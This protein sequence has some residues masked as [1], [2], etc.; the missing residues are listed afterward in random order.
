MAYGNRLRFVLLTLTIMLACARVA[1]ACS[2][3]PD[4]TVLDAYD[5]ADVVIIA[6]AVAVEKASP[7][8]TAPPGQ[9][10]DGENYVDGVKSTTMRVERLYKG[11]LKIGDE[12][13]F[14]QGGGADCVWTFNEKSIGEEYL[15]YLKRF[16]ESAH[17]IAITCGRGGNLK[18]MGDDLLYLNKMEK[19]RGK[20]R[21]SGTLSFENQTDE[22]VAGRK[23]RIVGAGRTY[24][25]E[26]DEDGVYEVYD[27]PAGTYYIEPE[28]PRGWRVANFWLSYSPSF[29]GSEEV[30]SPKKIPITLK[31]KKHAGL[32]IRFE[33]DNAVRG[34]IYDPSGR[35]MRGVCLDL[36]PADGSKGP[37]LADC[38]EKDGAFEID[39]IPPGS[40]VLVINDDGKVS[41]TE[42]FA[43][44]Y[45]PN[46]TKREEATVFHIGLGEFIENLQIYPPITAETITVEGIFT[47][48]DGK[49]VVGE[50]VSF[51]STRAAAN[52]RDEENDDRAETD[53]KGRFS[54]K[55]IKG[56]RGWLYGSMYTYLGE[57]EN[58]PQLDRL[59]KQTGESAPEMKTPPI[60]IRAETSIYG[61]QLRFPFPACKKKKE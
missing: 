29:A 13:I 31:E 59:I 2:C 4:P 50:A 12:M 33:I 23:I 52:G 40:Y 32:D 25:V 7:E 26:T 19:V 3:G 20:T 38:T 14:A 48:S 58:C 15:F 16:K 42:P 37:Y 39:E 55:I 1:S 61:V 34:H 6:R 51:K 17:W 27:V 49:P 56:S 60:E 35:P 9:M 57:F 45:Y 18:Y 43:T 41:S 36:V 11:N 8:K 5:H 47:Y 44:F 54:I 30:K 24:E 46:V 21:I 10:S 53:S 22:S 28:I